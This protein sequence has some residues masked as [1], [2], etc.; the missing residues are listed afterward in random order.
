MSTPKPKAPCRS[1]KQVA[2]T[3]SS[4]DSDLENAYIDLASPNSSDP[5]FLSLIH[6]HQCSITHG[7]VVTGFGGLEINVL[8]QKLEVQG[9]CTLFLQVV[10]KGNLQQL[11]CMNFIDGVRHMVPNSLLWFQVYLFSWL[12]LMFLKFWGFQMLARITMCVM[13][14]PLWK[15]LLLH[16]KFLA[17]FWDAKIWYN[18]GKCFIVRCLLSIAVLWCGP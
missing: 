5:H 2:P 16:F 14:S 18:R 12:F 11:K 4:D 8:L 7:H 13:S 3:G 1:K 15:I 6:F 10:C 9:W 17:S